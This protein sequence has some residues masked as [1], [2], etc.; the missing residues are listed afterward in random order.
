MADHPQ[1]GGQQRDAVLSQPLPFLFDPMASVFQVRFDSTADVSGLNQAIAKEQELE[2]AVNKTQAAL[3][4]QA[5]TPMA[6]KGASDPLSGGG[7]AL[8]KLGLGGSE[9]LARLNASQKGVA[10]LKAGATNADS[11][12]GAL[13]GGGMVAVAR[14]ATIAGAGIFAL[15]AGVEQLA[16]DNPALANSF[17]N[18]KEAGSGFFSEMVKEAAGNG[19]KVVKW[20]DELI[21]KLGGATEAQKKAQAPME[22]SAVLYNEAATAA[23]AYTKALREQKAAIDDLDQSIRIANEARD[24]G[25]KTEREAVAQRAELAKAEIESNGA[26]TA[27]EKAAK[28]KEVEQQQRE[29]TRNLDKQERENRLADAAD[30]VSKKLELNKK[31][32]LTLGAEKAKA[33]KYDKEQ[34]K[35]KQID[36]ADAELQQA[37]SEQE[38]SRIKAKAKGLK[39]ELADI[40]KAGPDLKDF[41]PEQSRK[42]QTEMADRADKAKEDLRESLAKLEQEKIKKQAEDQRA[43]MQAEQEKKLAEVQPV[44]A[45]E[46]APPE[47]SAED[48]N[49]MVDEENKRLEQEAR[50]NAQAAAPVPAG[51]ASDEEEDVVTGRRRR[52]GGARG[53]G[54]DFGSG[55]GYGGGGYAPSSGGGGGGD[56]GS[57]EPIATGVNVPGAFGVQTSGLGLSVG[58]S[59]GGV[60]SA[61]V[62]QMGGDGPISG[63]RR[64]LENMEGVVAGMS[65]LLAESVQRLA[66]H[67]AHVSQRLSV[68][69]QAIRTQHENASLMKERQAAIYRAANRTGQL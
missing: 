44:P 59:G 10:D 31:A 61:N 63:I 64:N 22:K 29:E 14:M 65:N 8:D 45:P 16:K 62:G 69:N 25:L 1:W 6:P 46:Q 7:S 38:K 2:H 32:E 28:I 42:L 17:D 21:V 58:G 18:L 41:D 27:E 48:F 35:Q 66:Q 60:S 33:A 55:G 20:M 67:G 24:Q 15:K 5:E 51:E 52:R 54:A 11:A 39:G 37:T 56:E 19:S 68:A 26:L 12:M 40:Q 49:R 9:F 13:A 30:E 43:E 4:K 53:Y 50:A 47:Q 23:E 3:K 36:L 57:A 34:A